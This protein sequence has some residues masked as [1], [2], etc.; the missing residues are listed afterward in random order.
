VSAGSV[1]NVLGDYGNFNAPRT[2]GIE[3]TLK[4]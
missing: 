2:Y 3:F 1:N 4:Y